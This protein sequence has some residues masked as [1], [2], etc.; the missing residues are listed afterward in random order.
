MVAASHVLENRVETEDHSRN[1]VLSYL[2]AAKGPGIEENSL[3]EEVAEV[4][5]SISA[6]E[7]LLALTS[8]LHEF[9]APNPTCLKW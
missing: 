6:G 9:R 4:Y 2:L 1:H 3:F 7:P 5:V 8:S